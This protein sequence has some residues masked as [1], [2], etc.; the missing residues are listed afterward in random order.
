MRVRVSEKTQIDVELPG[1]ARSRNTPAPDSQSKTSKE[2]H[3]EPIRRAKRAGAPVSDQQDVPAKATN[4]ISPEVR[5]W[6]DR[7]VLPI[8]EKVIFKV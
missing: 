4:Q 3:R 5:E 8:L 1:I 6:L 7:V 2:S